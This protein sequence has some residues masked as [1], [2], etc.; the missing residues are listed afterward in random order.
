MIRKLLPAILVLLT[1][2]ACGGK[3][4]SVLKNEQIPDKVR[5]ETSAVNDKLF[6]AV[7]RNDAEAVKALMSDTLLQKHKDGVAPL[8]Q[9]ASTSFSALT[10][11]VIDAYYQY[12]TDP[13]GADTI[14][15]GSLGTYP[16]AIHFKPVN[17]ETYIAL[18]VPEEDKQEMLI[19]AIY[20]RYGDK[21]KLNTIYFGVLSMFGKSAPDY[22]KTAKTAYEKQYLADAVNNADLALLCLK[23][24]GDLFH[25][26]AEKEIEGFAEK[27]HA[28]ALKTFA[29]PQVLENIPGKP[30]VFR[31]FPE[32]SEKGF[33]PMVYYKTN[34]PLS[35]TAAL[36]AEYEAVKKEV[37][38]LYKGI[39]KDKD[40]VFYRAYNQYPDGNR[41]VE[42][43]SFIQEI[44]VSK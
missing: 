35:N 13:A 3:K 5:K 37:S 1:F 24:G 12:N 11:K 32:S 14:F 42:Q 27:V 17:T 41:P 16:Y 36:E 40:Y 34:I 2:S 26:G 22:Y 4:P 18:L 43:Y 23:P 44:A 19:T 30:V 33:F 10:Y 6:R 15:S 7:S 31:I 28:E 39:D 38:R 29:F 9:N 25:F 8:I 21:W 20:G